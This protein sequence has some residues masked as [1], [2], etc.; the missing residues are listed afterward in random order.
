MQKVIKVKGLIDKHVDDPLAVTMY[1]DLTPSEY[2]EQLQTAFLRSYREKR[3]RHGETHQK[4][5]QGY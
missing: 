3:Q 4:R 5:P 1:D 2:L